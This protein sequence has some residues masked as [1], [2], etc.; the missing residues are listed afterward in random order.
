MKSAVAFVSLLMSLL[1]VSVVSGQ[2]GGER[3]KLLEQQKLL[4]ERIETLKREQDFLLFQK[5]MY[6]LDS[7]YLL[8]NMSA[9]T[10]QLKYKNRVLKD[11]R[12]VSGSPRAAAKIKQGP[13]MLTRRI[14]SARGRNALIFGKSVILQARGALS[15][16]G[17][18]A[19]RLS[20]SKK[21]F[22][23]I[24]YAVEDGARAYILQ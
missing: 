19:P 2:E 21:D 15:P 11:F 22:M 13:I 24:F 3:Y 4:S 7:K 1:L 14:E 20:L 23:A 17:T 12:F 8:I 10:G 18:D 6:G 9:K 16:A 5:T